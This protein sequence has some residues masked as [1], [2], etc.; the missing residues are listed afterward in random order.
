MKELLNLNEPVQSFKYLVAFIWFL[1]FRSPKLWS[2]KE[3][4]L[5]QVSLQANY[6]WTFTKKKHLYS[7]MVNGKRIYLT[8][9]K[10]FV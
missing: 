1:M 6:H 5:A 3:Y 7:K 9:T 2:N 8:S 4:M 10:R